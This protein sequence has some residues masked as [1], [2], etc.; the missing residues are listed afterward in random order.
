MG[1]KGEHVY[2]E[3]NMSRFTPFLNKLSSPASNIFR[4]STHRMVCILASEPRDK[5]AVEKLQKE[6]AM[7]YQQHASLINSS[8]GMQT[9]QEFVENVSAL[10]LD[11]DKQSVYF[12]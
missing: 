4:Y 9:Q 1:V 8:F 12:L 6:M 7:I 3:Q 11:S 2:Y 10:L 5:K